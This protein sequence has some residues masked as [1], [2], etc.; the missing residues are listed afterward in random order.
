MSVVE[1]HRLDRF[2]YFGMVLQHHHITGHESFV[3]FC[4]NACRLCGRELCGF[5]DHAQHIL[6]V[7]I[8]IP[9]QLIDCAPV[10]GAGQLNELHLVV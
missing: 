7:V 9:D 5:R 10:S 6:L 4:G 1:L 2:R 3:Q 8:E